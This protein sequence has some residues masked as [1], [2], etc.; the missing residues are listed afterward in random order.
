MGANENGYSMAAIATRIITISTGPV[1]ASQEELQHSR[2]KWNVNS[3]NAE[4]KFVHRLVDKSIYQSCIN[5]AS[6][7]RSEDKLSNYPLLMHEK[8][9]FYLTQHPGEIRN[10]TNSGTDRNMSKP[11]GPMFDWM[12]NITLCNSCLTVFTKSP[13]LLIHA[14]LAIL[15]DEAATPHKVD[16]Q[17]NS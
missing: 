9:I 17:T 14:Q 16:L 13:E 1:K 10:I 12:I 7:G 15:D 4:S 2:I 6:A 5:G 3:H 8:S 11:Y